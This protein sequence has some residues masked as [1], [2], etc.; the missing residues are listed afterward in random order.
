MSWWNAF[1]EAGPGGNLITKIGDSLRARAICRVSTRFEG[2]VL[3]SELLPPHAL[4]GEQPGVFIHEVPLPVRLLLFGGGPEIAP[5][6]GLCA[7]LGWYIDCFTHPS[8][9][10]GDFRPDGQTAAVVMN[11]HFGRDL[12]TLDRL[13]PARLPYVGL[14]GPRK[15][16]AELVVRM[17][18]YRDFDPCWL[19]PLHAPAGLDIG[20]ESP[21]EIALSIVS[22]VSAVLAGR[23]G[24]SL[25][26]RR[27][28][29]HGDTR[30]IIAAA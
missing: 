16:R 5:F 21:E 11:H 9:L 23:T 18:D 14:L 1:P 10:P 19:E 24:G 22:E 12:A 8:E 3:G 28:A 30:P 29:I 15:R 20:S 13:L 17:Q 4:V 2:E 6:R 7:N 26:Q 25:R 27:D